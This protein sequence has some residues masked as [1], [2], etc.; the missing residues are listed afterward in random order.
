MAR[1]LFI[2]AKANHLMHLRIAEYEAR[3]KLPTSR[4]TMQS[5]YCLKPALQINWP[6]Q[7]VLNV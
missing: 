7:S 1:H 4:A 2:L 5:A 6:L 3:F